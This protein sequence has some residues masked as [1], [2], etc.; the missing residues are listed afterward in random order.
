M[1]T[2]IIGW[3]KGPMHRF[4]VYGKQRSWVRSPVNEDCKPADGLADPDGFQSLE[5][6]GYTQMELPFQ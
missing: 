4:P 1:N 3:E 5:D 6:A 2:S